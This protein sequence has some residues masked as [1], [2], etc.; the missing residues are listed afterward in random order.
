MLWAGATVRRKF[1]EGSLDGGKEGV[2][3]GA[4]SYG[5]RRFCELRNLLKDDTTGKG[6]E[7]SRGEL[8]KRCN[9]GVVSGELE[10]T[11]EEKRQMSNNPKVLARSRAMGSITDKEERGTRRKTSAEEGSVR[12]SFC[13]GR[14]K[15]T[16]Y[17]PRLLSSFP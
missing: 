12:R 13:Q 17:G 1:T 4:C 10:A 11:S 8:A 6:L 5:A 15:G 9:G 16:P 2:W 7:P 3:E 14:S